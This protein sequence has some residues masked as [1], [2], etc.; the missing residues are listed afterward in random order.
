[1]ETKKILFGFNN[2]K[3]ETS[4][5]E[6]LRKIDWEAETY[7][8][9]SKAA[10]KDMIRK[11]PDLDAVV[12]TE[13]IDGGG[14]QKRQKYVAEEF[15]A[16][17]DESNA[18]LVVVIS[19]NWR[20]TDFMR[21]LLDAGITCAIFVSEKKGVM[22][23]D[24]ATMIARKRTKREAREYYGVGHE[25]ADLG[26]LGLDEFS[27]LYE[28]F[29]GRSGTPLENY[30][31]ICKNLGNPK[32]IADFT[33]RLPRDDMEYLASFE[34]F[35]AIMEALKSAGYDLKVRKPKTT[36]IGLSGTL[37][38]G[39]QGGVMTFSEKDADRA[40]AAEKTEAAAEKAENAEREKPK[41]GLFSFGGRK[42]DKQDGEDAGAE[43]D[44]K[45][46]EGGK[47]E[48]S[49]ISENVA[50]TKKED[51][52]TSVEEVRVKDNAELPEKEKEG[53]AVM[54]ETEEK[55]QDAATDLEFS[56]MSMEEMLA[57][58]GGLEQPAAEVVKREEVKEERGVGEE[59]APVNEPLGDAV[60]PVKKEA[61][62]EGPEKERQKKEKPVK[63]K[64]QKKDP[65]I[66]REDPKGDEPARKESAREAFA[67]VK[68]IREEEEEEIAREFPIF[69]DDF[70]DVELES[71][72][73]GKS[74]IYLLAVIVLLAL[75]GGL[76]CF[77][78]GGGF[79]IPWN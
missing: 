4:I 31:F 61:A 55:P 56:E 74:G 65:K 28:R 64:P 47:N 53:A 46:S 40:A 41:K 12:L 75:L 3:F 63:D 14:L 36:S 76:W 34:E 62:S 6:L 49:G 16:L 27:E 9:T 45:D 5:K 30:L 70:E 11:T 39:T 23:K 42:K 59:T 52:L 2:E 35:H 60:M 51:P 8:R 68:K 37:M 58:M 66:E 78:G 57:M 21:V 67:V 25:K 26:F 73:G 48:E 69:G 72:R 44:R 43:R 1:M 10:V 18:N 15:A 38:I 54:K 17:A 32:Q 24:V 71:T 13:S 7:A 77:G 29:R 20:G 50:G 33:K 19:E 22:A 79:E